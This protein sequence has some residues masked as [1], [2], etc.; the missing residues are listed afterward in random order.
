MLIIQYM[1]NRWFKI[2]VNVSMRFQIFKIWFDRQY[3]FLNL[4]GFW[5]FIVN[6]FGIFFIFIIL[7]YSLWWSD[8]F[9]NFLLFLLD[10][11]GWCLLLIIFNMRLTFWRNFV[12]LL[13]NIILFFMEIYVDVLR[14]KPMLDFTFDKLTL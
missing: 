6:I 3:F 11:F 5:F 9:V 1:K 14:T 8:H 12:L 7:D 10:A 4:F 2:L 13:F